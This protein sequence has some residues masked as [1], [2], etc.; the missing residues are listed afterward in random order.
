[1]IAGAGDR[2]CPAWHSSDMAISRHKQNHQDARQERR[3]TPRRGDDYKLLQH[4]RQLQGTE[5]I[6]QSFF[7]THNINE[8]IE[9]VL[10]T[11]LDVVGAE[12]GSVLLADVE[13]ERLVFRH[14]IGAKAELVYGKS[15][16]WDKGIAGDVYKSGKAAIISDVKQDSRHFPDVDLMA[17]YKTKDMITLPLKQWDGDPIGVLNVL[18]K[19]AGVL[20]EDD[21]APLTIITTFASLAIQ[22][23]RLFEEAKLAEIVRL[24]AD[25]GHDLRNL[26]YPVVAGTELLQS[27]LEEVFGR[28][29]HVEAVKNAASQE[30]CDEVIETIQATSRRIQD[31][32]KQIGDCVKGLTCEPTFAP[33]SP[34]DVVEAVF[35]TLHLVAKER[36]ISLRAEGLARLPRIM[37]DEHRLFNAF[38]NLVNNA[39]PEVPAGGSITIRGQREPGEWVMLS[40]ADTGRGMSPEIQQSLFTSRTISRKPGGIGLGTKIVK[41]AVDAH[42]GTIRV[43]SQEGVGTIFFIRLPLVPTRPDKRS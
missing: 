36:S 26:H 6:C 10:Q 21:L 33:C 32:I 42:T 37:A 23:A 9:K 38:Y 17:D 20:S 28:L 12:A 22:Q 2:A 14:V 39:L 30:L 5:R 41:D 25:I 19:R 29:P 7:Q 8:L 18:N 11:A 35:K 3:I 13:T 27:E 24:V 4:D 15:I 34:A 43:E 31:R 1:M 40:V 16:P